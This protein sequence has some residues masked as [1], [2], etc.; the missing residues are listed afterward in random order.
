MLEAHGFELLR[1]GL[2]LI[3]FGD[4]RG[5]RVHDRLADGGDGRGGGVDGVGERVCG[6]A[7]GGIGGNGRHVPACEASL[8]WEFGADAGLLSVDLAELVG[9][10]VLPLSW[11]WLSLAFFGEPA[12]ALERF[13]SLA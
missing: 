7:D 12:L 13:A 5:V 3:R 11:H 10:G 8:A 4:G 1:R 6:A 2:G 9:G